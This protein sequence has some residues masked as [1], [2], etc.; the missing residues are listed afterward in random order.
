MQNVQAVNEDDP[1]EIIEFC[2]IMSEF[3]IDESYFYLNGHKNSTTEI[4]K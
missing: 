1:N 4:L 2:E 3:L